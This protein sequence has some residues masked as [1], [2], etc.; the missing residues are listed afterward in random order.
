MD[1]RKAE[2][3]NLADMGAS[4]FTV[5]AISFLFG[6]VTGTDILTG[7]FIVMGLGIILG[8]CWKM[9]R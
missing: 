6:L 2:K 4:V 3:S 8:T 7:G 5:L 9:A 1:R